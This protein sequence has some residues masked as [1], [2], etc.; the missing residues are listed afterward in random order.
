MIKKI[1]LLI[2]FVAFQQAVMSQTNKTCETPIED[3]LLELNSISKCSIEEEISKKPGAKANSSKKQNIKVSTRRRVVRKRTAVTGISTN[4]G[5]THKIANIKEKASLV[6]SL[7]LESEEFLE[8]MP[9]N[10]VD[11]IPLFKKCENTPILEHEKC[12]KKEISNHIRK[13]FKYPEK[14]Y[15]ESIQ[16]RVYAQFII[17]KAGEVTELRIRGPYKGEILE[18]EVERIIKKLPNFKPGKQNGKAIKVKYGIPISFKIPGQ[19]P[20]NVK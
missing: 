5:A 2:V 7:N 14:A 3:P 19:K 6:G 1:L 17:D 9:F 12:F 10:L 11:E 13:N 18:K 4:T 16:G 15:S 20:S 8:N